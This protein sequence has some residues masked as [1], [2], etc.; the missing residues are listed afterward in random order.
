[1]EVHKTNS[2]QLFNFLQASLNK[3]E[4]VGDIRD[5]KYVIYARKSSESEEKQERSLGDQ[6]SECR[7]MVAELGLRI[8]EPP[9]QESSSASESDI[10]EKFRKMLEDIKKGKYDGIVTWHPDRLAR[11]MKE[12]GEI[13]DLLDKGII[14]DLKFVSAIFENSPNGKMLLGMNFVISK[15]YSDQ[16]GH[17]VDRGNRKSIEDGKFIGTKPPHGYLRNRNKY[18]EPDGQNHSLIRRAFEMRLSGKSL[19]DIALFLNESGYSETLA[20]GTQRTCKMGKN[21]VSSFLRNPIY[22]GI[23]LH[24]KNV[25]NLLEVYNFIPIISQENFLE[26]NKD[27]TDIRS[28][29]LGRDFKLAHII[30]KVGAK[31]ADLMNGMIICGECNKKMSA[32]ITTKPATKKKYFLYRCDTTG[33]KFKNKSV[34]A[35]VIIKFVC[36]FLEKMSFDARDTYAHFS[37]DMRA[38]QAS[39]AREYTGKLKVLLEKKHRAQREAEE[40]KTYIPTEKDESIRRIY[41]E[42]LKKKL[43]WGDILNQEIDDL[44]GVIEKNRSAVITY[45]EFLELFQDLAQK[46]RKFNKLNQIDNVV[47]MFFSNFVMKNKK[48]AQYKLKP[49]FD[50][51]VQGPILTSSPSWRGR[52]DSNRRP[53]A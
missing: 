33:C 15:Q 10:R 42:D 26:I 7:K 14:K 4:Q 6:V 16:L 44:R 13:I 43:D 50:R 41:T 24:G 38:V 39:K 37:K 11:N 29:K 27:V 36:S 51:M 21:K 9:I 18:L 12:A 34:R 40:I 49:P 2:D 47:R 17:N 31:K 48:I 45:E 25:V 20:D 30:Q 28:V 52:P 8:V 19:D 22:T 32:G 5:Y 23:Y 35:S 3:D 53:T 46:V 1:M